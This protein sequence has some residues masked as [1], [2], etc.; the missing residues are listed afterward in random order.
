[1]LKNVDK[2]RNFGQKN[3]IILTKIGRQLAHNDLIGETDK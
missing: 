1:M 2:L 3:H